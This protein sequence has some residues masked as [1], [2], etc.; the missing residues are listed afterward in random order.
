MG[1]PKIEKES[2]KHY[3]DDMLKWYTADGGDPQQL[4]FWFDMVVLMLYY[5]DQYTLHQDYILEQL[6]IEIKDQFARY[7]TRFKKEYG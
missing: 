5:Y 3:R 6:S 4:P 2:L 7:R 1:L